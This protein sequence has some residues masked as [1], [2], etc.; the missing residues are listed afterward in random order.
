MMAIEGDW[1]GIRDTNEESIWSIFE[2][3]V[4]K[5]GRS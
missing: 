1:S 2:K 5:G 4:L 3:H